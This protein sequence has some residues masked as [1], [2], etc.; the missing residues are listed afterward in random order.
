MPNLIRWLFDQANNLYRRATGGSVTGSTILNLRDTYATR[1][2]DWIAGTV[3]SLTNGNVTLNQ[4]TLGFRQELKN[5]YINQYALARGGF[6]AMTQ[7]DWGRI[8]RM[9]RDQYGYMN[10]FAADIATGRLSPKQIEARMQLYFNSSTQAYERGN[11]VSH[12]IP[13]LPQYPGDGRTVC[14]ANCQCVWDIREDETGWDCF[15]QLGAAEHCP[16]CLSNASRWAPLRI[17][18]VLQ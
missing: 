3:S 11:A 4:W 1:K 10:N 15:W 7:A 13:A 17:P 12:G 2:A 18:K 16:D 14:R 8:G 6:N 5:L 9:L